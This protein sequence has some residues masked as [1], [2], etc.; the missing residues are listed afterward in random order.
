MQ[1]TNRTTDTTA[2]QRFGQIA[3]GADVEKYW[4]TDNLRWSIGLGTIGNI[5]LWS[6]QSSQYT[7]TEQEDINAQSS[8]QKSEIRQLGIR[9]PLTTSF[10]VQEDIQLGIG[11]AP[12]WLMNWGYTQYAVDWTHQFDVSPNISIHFVPSKN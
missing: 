2:Q 12:I 4:I 9:F 1:N 8:V 5:P 6:I 7:S 10:N 3:L 11:I